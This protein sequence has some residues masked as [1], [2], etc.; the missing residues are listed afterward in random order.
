VP[1]NYLD[2]LN[3]TSIYTKDGTHGVA[4]L[5]TYHSL[6]CLVRAPS[7]HSGSWDNPNN[8]QKKVK[9]MLFKE[10]YHTGKSEEA[11]AREMKH[12]GMHS[13]PDFEF[14]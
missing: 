5:S 11:M 9:R 12:V 7:L 3:L 10:Y 4:S 2:E 8:K 14:Y 1:K 13:I 6:H